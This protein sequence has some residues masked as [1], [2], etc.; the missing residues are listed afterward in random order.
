[1]DGSS[2]TFGVVLGCTG[3]VAGRFVTRRTGFYPQA[4]SQTPPTKQDRDRPVMAG[5]AVLEHME[6][7]V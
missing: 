5:A 2:C 4:L 3:A 1:M 7:N 6:E